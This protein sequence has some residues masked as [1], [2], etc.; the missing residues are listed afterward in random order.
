MITTVENSLNALNLALAQ[1]G[2]DS[3]KLGI[4]K[5]FVTKAVGQLDQRHR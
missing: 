1:L 4:H 3:K 2:T 5:D